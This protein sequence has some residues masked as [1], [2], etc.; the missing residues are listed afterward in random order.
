[1]GDRGGEQGG[2]GGFV[3]GDFQ[4]DSHGPED[5]L[6]SGGKEVQQVSYGRAGVAPHVAHPVLQEGL[7]KD[8]G[9]VSPEGLSRTV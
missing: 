7:C 5:G 1:M 6:V 3:V 2:G 8:E 4:V 9:A